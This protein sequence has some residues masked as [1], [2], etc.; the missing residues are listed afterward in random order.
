MA[1]RQLP[2]DFKEFIQCLNLNKVKYL[3]IGGWAVGI[4]GNPRATKDIDFLIS[5]KSDNLKK[6]QKALLDFGAPPVDIG[7]FREKGNVIRI[8]S[9]PIQI[10]IINTA[11]GISIDDCYPR[12]ETINVDDTEINVISRDDLIKNK[13]ASG[14]SMDIADAENLEKHKF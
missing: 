14:R 6:I 9:S 3:L 1:T 11:D 5:A 8:G 7:Y 4:Y 13:R 2:D 10:D 12:K